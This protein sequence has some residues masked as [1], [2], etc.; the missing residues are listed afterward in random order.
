MVLS[1]TTI[2]AQRRESNNSQNELEKFNQFYN[3][4]DATYIDN[5]DMQ[6]LI[7]ES[8]RAILAE[9]DPH[10]AYLTADEMKGVEESF[11]GE[12]SGI[13]IEFNVINDTLMVV[14]TIVGAPAESVGVMPNDRII[15]IDG[16]SAIGISMSD[17]PKKL[18][19]LRGTKVEIEV[20]RSGVKEPLHF[21]IV[22]DNIPLH[23]IDANYMVND[24]T[25][26]LR[27]NRFGHTT[28]QEFNQAYSE[29]S[30]VKSII[31]DLRGNGGGLLNEAIDM[32]NFFLPKG[33]VVVYTQGRSY[34]KM[35][36]S[37]QHN[38]AF[39]DGDVVVIIDESSASASE[40]VAGAIQDWDRGII[41]GQASFGKGLIQRQYPLPDGSAARITVAQ[42][43]TP[44]G[45]AIQRPYSK[46]EGEEYYREHYERFANSDDTLK[47][48]QREL[49]KTLIKERD[50]YGGGGITPD[51]VVARDTTFSSA[52]YFSLIRKGLTSEFIMKY[53]DAN[54]KKLNKEY[55]TFSE[56]LSD[57][58]V[59][60]EM[61][62]EL[63]ALA[64]D[65]SLT[66]DISQA[67]RWQDI[68]KVNLKAM[69]A[70]RL[71]S[72]SEFYQ[73]TNQ[74]DST[75]IKAVEIMLK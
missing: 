27:V 11:S 15:G 52:L 17:V 1:L 58:S 4:L 26:Y 29:H 34:P 28:M 46:G 16:E 38:G 40:I 62:N 50:V 49:F 53:L 31:L 65:N 30:G 43:L 45:R 74:E 7:E 8:I 39:L 59:D 70:Q 75:Y 13:G 22:R 68:A 25:L 33:S 35:A 67:D 72:S 42:Y 9:L 66:D 51:I 63:Y 24:S 23:T 64:Q 61:L 36:I 56:F 54:R 37:T 10:S 41:V 19:G 47:V 69:L 48:E 71:F 57:F 60:E 55:P 12:F 6:P 73:V 20:L 5:L 44:S 21:L 2:T 14:N 32:A 3:I 18:K